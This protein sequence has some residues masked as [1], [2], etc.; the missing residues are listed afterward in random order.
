MT[1][2]EAA[3]Q[4]DRIELLNDPVRFSREIFGARLW[5]AEVDLLYSIRDRRRTAVKACHGAGKTF[6]LALA[7]LWWLSRYK[8][9]IVLTTAPTDRQVKTQLWSEIHRHIARCE[10]FEF[11]EFNMKDIKLRGEDNFAMGLSTNRTEN[12]QGYHGRQ[13]LIVAD[14]APGIQAGIWDAIEGTTAGGRVHIVQAGNPTIPSGAFFDAF[15]QERELWNCITIDALE[16]PNLDD[17]PSQDPEERLKLVLDLERFDGG[18]LD[19]NPIPY[20]V[21]K[22]WVVDHWLQWW[23]GDDDNS[24]AWVSRVRGRFPRQASNALFRMAWLERAARPAKDSGARL[25]AGIDVG[26]GDA[27]TSVKICEV[28]HFRKSILAEGNWRGEDTR[29][30]VAQFLAPYKGRLSAVRV[31]ADGIG[32]NFALHFRDLGYPI[33]M[34]HVGLPCEDKP[35]LKQENPRVRFVNL[36]AQ[37]YQNVADSFERDEVEGLTDSKTLGQ[38]AGI[39]YELDS[40]GRIKIEPKEKAAE[41]GVPSPDRAEALMLALGPPMRVYEFASSRDLAGPKAHD[42]DRPNLD[43]DDYSEFIRG[44]G[45]RFGWRKGGY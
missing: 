40:H 2:S 1:K 39:L 18:P 7:V 34:V 13:V 24:P 23:H 45:G 38:L 8:H 14:E 22:R 9:G 6:T 27:E 4:R 41:R 5:K 43:E 21:T 31:D 3:Q 12:F 29:G 42:S 36:K 20:L 19:R 16:T 25:I 15:G 17:L 11:P 33:E 26:G 10:A 30:P 35:K 28:G 44:A 32:H 37:Y